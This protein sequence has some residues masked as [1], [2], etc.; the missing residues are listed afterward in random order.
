M[1]KQVKWVDLVAMIAICCLLLAAYA[2]K[3]DRYLFRLPFVT[4]LTFYFVGKSVRD[5]E[6][7]LWDK[8]HPALA[9]TSRGDSA[10]GREPL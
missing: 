2:T 4:L 5:Y 10:L 8:K 3:W 7:R 9:P 1:K 6:L